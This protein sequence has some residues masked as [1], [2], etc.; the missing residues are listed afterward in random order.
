M[1]N[2]KTSNTQIR[3]SVACGDDLHFYEVQVAPMTD[4]RRER[5][6]HRAAKVFAS[7]VGTGGQK[8][9]KVKASA[10]PL[11]PDSIPESTHAPDSRGN[12]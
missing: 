12:T 10:R 2:L 7:V 5:L 1:T 9:R 11:T 6:L 3:L 4:Q 8:R